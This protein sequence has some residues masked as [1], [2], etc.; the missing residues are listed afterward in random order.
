MNRLLA[1][2]I[3]VVIL[4]GAACVALHATI[5]P[6]PAVTSGDQTPVPTCQA[7]FNP[8]TSGWCA[9]RA[10]TSVDK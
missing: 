6:E 1:W 3:L 9:R 2:V 7:V 5:E 4:D 8:A 10:S